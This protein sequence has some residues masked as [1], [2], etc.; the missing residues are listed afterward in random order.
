MKI[1]LDSDVAKVADFMLN[2]V[3]A[4]ELQRVAH[5]IADLANFVWAPEYILLEQKPFTLKWAE[6]ISRAELQRPLASKR[7]NGARREASDLRGLNGQNK[8]LP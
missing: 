1:V 7:R 6:E 2:N 3:R 5:A 4:L 8:S